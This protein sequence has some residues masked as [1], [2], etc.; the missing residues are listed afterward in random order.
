M[1][2]TILATPGS[3]A[4]GTMLFGKNSD[5]QR[6]E[7]EAL[8]FWP[9]A[10]HAVGDEVRCTYMAIPQAPRTNAVFLCRPFWMWG[11]EMG[12]NEHGLVIGNEAVHAKVPA[13][14]EAALLGDDLVR[15]A[16]ERSSTAAQAVEIITSLLERYGQG[17]NNGHLTPS[18]FNNAF[19]ISDADE[20]YVLET[21]GREWMLERPE[22]VRS[23]SNRYSIGSGV[24]RTSRGLRELLKSFGWQGGEP[25]DYSDVVANPNREHIGFAGA[26]RACTQ[27]LLTARAGSL[28]VADMM[29]VLRDHGR[30]EAPHP[31][32]PADAFQRRMV[33]MHA[34]ARD[35]TGQT[36]GAMVSELG[37]SGAVHWVTGTAAPCTSVFKPVFL[38]A[39]LPAAGLQPSDVFDPATLWWRHEQIHRAAVVGD[40][41]R[42]LA[43]FTGERDELEARFRELVR[44]AAGASCKE[45]SEVVSQCWSEAADFEAA[46]VERMSR[47]AT[48]AETPERDGWARMNELAGIPLRRPEVV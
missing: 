25:E 36:T 17:G 38:D 47:Y 7:A 45:R 10:D 2:D 16:L 26:R 30:G 3:T 20:A 19:M 4:D 6:N 44:Q 9:A 48:D 39:P 46:W 15:L 22:G 34:G 33:C 24:I 11:A 37:A 1:C 32:W 5:R 42:F 43:D 23:M 12:A 28:T 18:F 21:I 31:A 8:E 35:N 27:A 40:M 29:A 13:H 14:E 41:A